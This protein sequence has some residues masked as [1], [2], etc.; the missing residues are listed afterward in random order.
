MQ[1]NAEGD[2][3]VNRHRE[4]GGLLEHHAHLR[5]ER[6]DVRGIG[7]D[8]FAVHHHLTR[9]ALARVK[10]VHTVQHAEQRGFAAAGRPDHAR[11]LP[12]RQIKLDFLQRAVIAIEEIQIAD[13]HTRIVQ[14]GF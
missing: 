7:N 2:V 11:D 1:A 9:R 6:I 5:A 12:V 3:F 10:A 14:R 8:V 4:G 13:R